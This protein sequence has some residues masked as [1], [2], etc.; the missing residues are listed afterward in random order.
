MKSSLLGY[1]CLII[2]ILLTGIEIANTYTDYPSLIELNECDDTDEKDADD[3]EDEIKTQPFSPIAFLNWD[4]VFLKKNYC[5]ISKVDPFNNFFS[6]PIQEPP[7][8]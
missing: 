2:F 4:S 1:F 3:G 8:C 6:S 5:L 7:E